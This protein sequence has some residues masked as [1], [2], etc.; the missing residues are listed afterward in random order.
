MKSRSML[1]LSLALVLVIVVAGCISLPKIS[2]LDKN[3]STTVDN[4]TDGEVITEVTQH[5]N[6]T[7]EDADL[8]DSDQNDSNLNKTNESEINK[9]FEDKSEVDCDARLDIEKHFTN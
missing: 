7:T 2:K 3:D 9:T 4:E 5:A 1:V 8:N 6:N